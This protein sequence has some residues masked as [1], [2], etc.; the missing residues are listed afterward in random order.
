[1]T[2]AA[3]PLNNTERTHIG[4]ARRICLLHPLIG[5]GLLLIQE[6]SWAGG[7]LEEQLIDSVRSALGSAL[8]STLLDPLAL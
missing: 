8:S 6:R 2:P 7:Q 5:L 4:I 3:E 1:M